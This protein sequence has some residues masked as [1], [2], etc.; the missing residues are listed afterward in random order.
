MRTGFLKSLPKDDKIVPM[1]ELDIPLVHELESASQPDP[2]SRQHFLDE[3]KN[4]VAS[5]DL[6][7]HDEELA[8]FLCSWLVAGEMQIQNI[9]TS[10]AMRRKG[11]A[12]RLLEHAI[13]R[14]KAELTSVVL[15]VRVSN[16]RAQ[17]FYHRYGFR[18][19]KP[20]ARYYPDGED[21]VLMIRDLV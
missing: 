7:W 1:S 11:I 8:G 20:L 17:E 5:V 3:L 9:A 2:W 15:E 18:T 10:P 19:Q 4:P 21:G 12:A 13:E 16:K 14:S 6:Y